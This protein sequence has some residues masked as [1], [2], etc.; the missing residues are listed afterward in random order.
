AD[1][2]EEA[3][4]EEP[5]A[6]DEPATDDDEPEEDEQEREDLDQ[7][8]EEITERRDELD[9]EE[10]ELEELTERVEELYDE[11]ADDQ[12]TLEDAPEPTDLVAFVLGDE[13]GRLELAVVDFGEATIAGEQ[14]IPVAQRQLT[15]FQGN[16]VVAH[17]STGRL[18][19]LD[20]SS[21]S[22]IAESDVPA[23]PG[24]RIRV[25][26]GYLLTVIPQ[27]DT[28]VVGEFDAQL[29]L[30]RR[31]ARPVLERTDIVAREDQLLVQGENG[32][33][34]V[35]RLDEVAE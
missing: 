20:P 8:E 23:V 27:D 24:S 19:M 7:R 29:V 26:D 28:F 5:A 12:A 13:T 17:Q 4:E 1:T 15:E 10:E 18:L 33:L 3:P 11:T 2:D 30:Q 25:V 9:E 32:E 22:V 31:S 14:T 21:L 6:A 35:L 34:R 16:I